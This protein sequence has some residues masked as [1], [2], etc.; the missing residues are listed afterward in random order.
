MK[1]SPK[2]RG[3][4]FHGIGNA[5]PY[6]AGTPR[7]RGFL[8]LR[9]G[10]GSP[11]RRQR[12]TPGQDAGA[13]PEDP[14]AN[15]NPGDTVRNEAQWQGSA[16][17]RGKANSSGVASHEAFRASRRDHL[18][19][20]KPVRL[21]GSEDPVGQVV[22]MRLISGWRDRNQSPQGA[23][24]R[25]EAPSTP[26]KDQAPASPKAPLGILTSAPKGDA[27]GWKFPTP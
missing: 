26:A 19:V 7:F 4:R 10:R 3:G 12:R 21:Q 2:A 27:R 23:V 5:I 25:P 22:G 11:C 16:T 17:M 6:K 18:T 24:H 14:A 13:H 8:D 20:T 15:D 9:R 1:Q